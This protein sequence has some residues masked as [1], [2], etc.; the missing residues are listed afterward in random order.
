VTRVSVDI[1]GTF[2]DCVVEADSAI[3]TYKV[4]TTPQEP[5]RGVLD[6]LS[7]AAEASN[8]SLEQFLGRVEQLFHG[9]TLGTN[10]LLTKRG[11]KVAFLT[12]AHFRDVIEM[13]RGIRN[14]GH[15]VFDQIRPNYEPLVPRSLRFGIS[16]RILYSGEVDQ[17]LDEAAVE[18]AVAT[19]VDEG[20]AAIAIGFL[21]SYANPAHEQQAKRIVERCA[22]DLHVVCSSDVLPTLGEFERFSTTV[23]SAYVGRAVSTYLRE[24]EGKLRESGFGGSL[25]IMLSSGLMQTVDQCH[26][27]AVELLASGPAAAPAAALAVG[28]P[29]GQLDLLEVDMGGTSFEVCVIQGGTVPTTKDAWVGEERVATKMVEIRSLGAGG[30][31]IAWIDSLGLLRVGPQSAGADPGPAAYGKSELPT[32]T[33]ADLI[34]GFLPGDFFLGGQISLDVDRAAAAVGSLGEPLG[35][36]LEETADAIFQTITITMAGAVTEACTKRGHDVRSFAIVAGGGAGGIHSAP[37]AEHLGIPTVIFPTAQPVLSAMGMLIM[38][39]G[40]EAAKVGVWERTEVTA[41]QLEETFAEMTAAEHET[42][43]RMGVDL[44]EVT[45]VRSIAARYQGQFSEVSIDVLPG[46]DRE[47]LV[48]RF[49]DRYEEIYGYALPW[50]AVEILECHLR[51][52]VEQPPPARLAE[53]ADPP[54]LKDAMFGERRCYLRGTHVDVPVYY[55]DLLHAGHSFPGPALIDSRTSTILVPEAFDA[56]VDADRNVIL[57]LRDATGMPEAAGA[58]ERAP[59]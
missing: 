20:C 23:V 35:F 36:N 11:D 40:Q 43:E 4:P 56:R 57:H 7:K 38:E 24:L 54:P 1:G 42:F 51:G 34:L 8:E 59:A 52:S 53:P 45:F 26:G 15:S 48:Q 13:R 50:R 33:D 27:R 58:A 18:A 19:A 2:T 32:V 6:A 21:H 17:P 47:A 16:E 31:S 30:G 55:R 46:D 41:E 12:T 10:L 29:L 49:R 14:L 5:A 39:I 28:K 9:T 3:E 37:I 44:S 25:L 22:P